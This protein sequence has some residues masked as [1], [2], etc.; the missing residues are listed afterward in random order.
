MTIARFDVGARMSQCVRHGDT[1]YLAG[2]VADDCAGGVADQSRQILEKID[3]Y[4]AD[5]GSDK[6]KLLQCHIWLT[7]MK[8]YADFNTVWDAW[9]APREPPARACVRAEL[10][11]PEWLV[12]VMAIAATGE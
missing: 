6:S 12:E 5:A 3:R 11:R 2:L 9:I 10:A 1:I 7:D 8:N 4:L